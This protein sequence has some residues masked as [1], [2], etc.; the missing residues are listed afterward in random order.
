MVSH[1]DIKS[2]HYGPQII[3]LKEDYSTLVADLESLLLKKKNSLGRSQAELMRIA[4]VLKSL[5]ILLNIGIF[6]KGK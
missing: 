1:K 5:S 2:P 6:L 3:F 4:E